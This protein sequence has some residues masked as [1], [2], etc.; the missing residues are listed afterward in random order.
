MES[1]FD[2][3][4]LRPAKR[5][6]VFCQHSSRL[7]RF[8][9]SCVLARSKDSR[10]EE[11]FGWTRTPFF[12][13][14]L[15]TPATD[16]AVPSQSRKLI[17][18]KLDVSLIIKWRNV[19]SFSSALHREIFALATVEFRQAAFYLPCSPEVFAAAYVRVPPL[20]R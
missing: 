4:K 14:P 3:S 8:S 15:P 9:P 12:F 19:R 16:L 6:Y 20:E 11:S 7:P 10:T 1:H 2:I 17:G 18:R 5:R 13:S